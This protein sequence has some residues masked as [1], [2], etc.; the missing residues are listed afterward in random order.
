M[1][2]FALKAILFYTL[3]AI[4][5]L[6]ITGFTNVAIYW[7]LAVAGISD[8]GSMLLFRIALVLAEVSISIYC[9][10]MI[11]EDVL[12]SDEA[13]EPLTEEEKETV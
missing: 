11:S 7:F 8:F 5:A 12:Y 9:V 1:K 3:A 2:N 13:E 4:C 6:T 10:S